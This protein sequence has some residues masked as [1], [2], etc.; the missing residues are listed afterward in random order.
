[1]TGCT[2]FMPYP[3]PVPQ[4]TPPAPL[5]PTQQ[6][7]NELSARLDRIDS[8]MK[9]LKQQINGLESVQNSSTSQLTQ[10][11]SKLET[12]LRELTGITEEANHASVQVNQRIDRLNTDYSF[13]LDRLDRLITA[14]AEAAANG[15]APAAGTAA[16]TGAGAAAAAGAAPAVVVAPLPLARSTTP[17]KAELPPSRTETNNAN[18]NLAL[19]KEAYAKARLDRAQTLLEAFIEDNPGN[20]NLAEASF[21]LGKVYYDN[22]QFEN[23]ASKFFATYEKFPRSTSAPESL[24]RLGLT[25]RKL[26]RKVESCS[27]LAQVAVDYPKADKA[28]LTKAAAARERYK[29]R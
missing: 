22:R 5:T 11:F 2:Q 23:A 7:L 16:G 26:E 20:P 3:K 19:A 21:I 18:K 6:K 12:S 14:A 25:L 8:G 24:Y 17:P 10:K 9:E 13:R 29:C 27:A 15:S 28:L 1:M 4:Q